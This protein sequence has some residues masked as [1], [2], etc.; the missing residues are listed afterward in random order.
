MMTYQE[1]QA[2]LKEHG[3]EQLLKYYDELSDKERAALLKQISSINFSDININRSS[4]A[5]RLGELSPVPA[6]SCADIE[7]DRQKY[8]AAGLAAIRAGKVAAVLLAGG[9][10]TRLGSDAPK[11]TYNIGK[12][13]E[14]SI[15]E[16]QFNNIREGTEKAEACFHIFIMTS[17]INNAATIEFF[18]RK[19][20]FGYPKEKVHFFVQEMAPACDLGGKVLL[21]DKGRI[22]MSP[23]GNG[24]WYYSLIKNGDGDILSR[25]GIEWLNVYAVDNVLQR[26]CDPVFIGATLQSGCNC[27]AKVVKKVSPEER[28]GVLCMEDGRPAIVEYYEMPQDVAALRRPDGEL[29]FAYGVIL[30]YLFKTEL[31]NG[32][33]GKKLP[34]HLSLKKIP[35][36]EDGALVSP[37]EPNG[38]KFEHLVL[39]MIKLMGSC[40]AVEVVREREFAPVKNR[41]GVD[42]VESARAL[43]EKNGIKL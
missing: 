14:L 16:C 35:H 19:D 33:L 21:E 5:R 43:L 7:R 8:E 3:Q 31:L 42:S 30:N 10:G 29:K 4:A 20:Y 39:D 24:G 26:I 27:S 32:T 28:V 25:E 37:S 36:I 41:T 2:L 6:L 18:E 12:T 22:A 9:Q 13:R 11:G 1:A 34:V 38:Y 40:L 23:N 17:E 15:F